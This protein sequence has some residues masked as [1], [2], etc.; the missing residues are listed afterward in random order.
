MRSI[1]EV[2]AL[3]CKDGC[4]GTLAITGPYEAE[5][6]YCGGRYLVPSMEEIV[7]YEEEDYFYT[8]PHEDYFYKGGV[9]SRSFPY[10]TIY[11]ERRRQ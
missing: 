4:G 11:P 6:L 10:G 9:E 8:P 7:G 3:R 5:C 2:T 1:T